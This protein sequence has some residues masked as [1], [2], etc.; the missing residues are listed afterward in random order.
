MAPSLPHFLTLAALLFGIGLTGALLRRNVI[1]IYMGIE[2]MLNAAALE[3][4]AFARATDTLDGAVLVF[5]V[6]T[7]AAAEVA[8]GL[9]LITALFRKRE[10]VK[11]AD[12]KTLKN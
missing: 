6:I 4:V 10:S 11:A 3:L 5:F 2:L 12:L 8:V 9:A 1:V 7:V